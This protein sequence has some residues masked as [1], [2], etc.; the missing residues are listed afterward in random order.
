MDSTFAREP[1]SVDK[2][3]CTK[4]FIRLRRNAHR[5]LIDTWIQRRPRSLC[6]LIRSKRL[7]KP[8]SSK[9]TCYT[10]RDEWP[11]VGIDLIHVWLNILV[12]AKV[13]ATQY[14]HLHCRK[15]NKHKILT[16]KRKMSAS[17]WASYT[18]KIICMLATKSRGNQRKYI[19]LTINS[20]TFPS[21]YYMCMLLIA[22]T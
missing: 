21:H 18:N 9:V 5:I 12:L 4:D 11:N 6:G 13:W 8:A 2:K 7:I 10:H 22:L 19:Q 15:T 3:K 14:I 1:Y 20:N 17:N 16:W